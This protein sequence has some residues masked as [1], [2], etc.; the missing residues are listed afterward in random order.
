M[1]ESVFESL[2]QEE[3][4]LARPRTLILIDKPWNEVPDDERALLVKILGSVKLSLAA[5]QIL[6]RESVALNDLSALN[7]ERVISFGTRLSPVNRQY[8]YVPI[9]GYHIIVSDS[10]SALDDARK[11]SLWLALRQMF[12]L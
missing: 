3:I 11:K 10:L 4:Y 8:E 12:G 9:D 7:P 6:H 2:Y 5:V 1:A